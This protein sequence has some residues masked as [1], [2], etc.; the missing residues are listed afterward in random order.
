MMITNGTVI[1]PI[2]EFRATINGYNS[3]TSLQPGNPFEVKLA[4]RLISGW[5][6]F[7]PSVNTAVAGWAASNEIEFRKVSVALDMWTIV[8]RRGR[9]RKNPGRGADEC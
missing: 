8:Y 9:A 3:T 5:V 4:K 1:L 2:N 6:L 7:F